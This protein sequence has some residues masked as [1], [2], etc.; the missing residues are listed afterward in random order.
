MLQ[1]NN[2]NFWKERQQ[3]LKDNKWYAR[4]VDGIP[5]D[6]TKKATGL[7]QAYAKNK[8]LYNGVIDTDWG[9]LTE[10]AYQSTK[11]RETD[12]SN[13]VDTVDNAIFK[14]M[15]KQAS[16]NPA[17]IFVNSVG[18]V[19][20]YVVLSKYKEMKSR[21]DKWLK[22][23]NEEPKIVYINKPSQLKPI[24]PAS[25][26]ITKFSK[27]V[28]RTIT[29][30][31]DIEAGIKGRRWISY[32]NDKYDEETALKRLENKSG[33]NCTDICQLVYKALKMLGY[34]VRFRHIMCRDGGHIQV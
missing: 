20:R 9:D 4:Q 7:F 10:K 29:K 6:F 22:D 16:S 30:A 34:D 11:V 1:K 31:A 26:F 27:A 23:N 25:N 2:K 3:F 28:G 17:K 8:G 5:G 21:W 33:L 14:N 19:R 15:I 12:F 32:Y 18:S 24:T 13:S